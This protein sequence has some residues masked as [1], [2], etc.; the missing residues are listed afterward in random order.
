[1]DLKLMKENRAGFLLY[2]AIFDKRKRIRKSNRHGDLVFTPNVAGKFIP[3]DFLPTLDTSG[4]SRAYCN[5]NFYENMFDSHVEI[6]KGYFETNPLTVKNMDWASHLINHL[7]TSNK[8]ELADSELKNLMLRSYWEVSEKELTG[9]ESPESFIPCF[10]VESY[11]QSAYGNDLWNMA[12]HFRICGLTTFKQRHS[13]DDN[14]RMTLGLTTL[15]GSTNVGNNSSVETKKIGWCLMLKSEYY[16]DW[17]KAVFRN[18]YLD[19]NIIISDGDWKSSHSKRLSTSR[20]NTPYVT[21]VDPSWFVFLVDKAVVENV[22]KV[23]EFKPITSCLPSLIS[24]AEA[25]DIEIKYVENHSLNRYA[26]KFD[27]NFVKHLGNDMSNYEQKGKDFLASISKA[28]KRSL[29]T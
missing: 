7:R 17:C 1:M 10:M 23:R 24:D 11:V 2:S 14:K 5:T 27:T 20:N 26:S 16:S 19:T 15:L 8:V 21:Q 9:I 6:L 13:S 25:E 28:L 12:T 4:V 29:Q 22:S 18:Q 3:V